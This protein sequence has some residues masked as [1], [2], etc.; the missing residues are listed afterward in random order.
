VLAQARDDGDRA[1]VCLLRDGGV[2]DP[3][4]GGTDEYERAYAQ[5][6]EACDR[7]LD[8]VRAALRA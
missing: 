1:K 7:L 6:D 4:H 8:E 5:I 3:F 2:A